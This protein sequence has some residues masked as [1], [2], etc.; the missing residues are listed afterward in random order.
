[1]ITPFQCEDNVRSNL[2]EV[3]MAEYA[4]MVTCESHHEQS[5]DIYENLFAVRPG[6]YC[7]DKSSLER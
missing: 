7:S 4:T 5:C 1:M 3:G 2:I 6:D